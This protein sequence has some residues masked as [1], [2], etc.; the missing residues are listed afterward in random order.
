MHGMLQHPLLDDAIHNPV[1]RFI[2]VI[3]RGVAEVFLQNNPLTGLIFLIGIFINSWMAGLFALLGTAVSTLTAMVLG[4]PREEIDK[5]MW[6]LNGTLTGLA[7]ELYMKHNPILVAYVIL[8][9][10][11]VTIVQAFIQDLLKPYDVPVLT[12]PFVVTTLMFLAAV[13]AFARIGASPSL[14]VA[15]LTAHAALS[16]SVMSFSAAWHGFF[17][18]VAQ[19]MLQK[20]IWTGV[21]FLV[22]LLVN[23]RI[24]CLAAIVGSLT[25]LGV[26]WA[27][28]G[29]PVAF[30]AGLYGFNSVLTAVD[31]GGIY[32]L[33][34][35]R[36]IVFSFVATIVTAVVYGTLFIVLAPVG[37]PVLTG[38]FVVVTWICLIGKRSLKQLKPIPTDK[39]STAEH[40]LKVAIESAH[41]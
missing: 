19:V 13:Y 15:H 35:G 20:N 10:I 11:F 38:A 18:G 36:S 16:T 5:G 3:L 32:L 9:A 22:G 12:G 39:I 34:S 7:L 17:N 8:A 23:S 29:N 4:V 41:L 28:A 40:H 14:T 27:L 6:G 2:D 31:L 26:A 37:L 21:A 33:L 30:S 1:S 24:S 25:G